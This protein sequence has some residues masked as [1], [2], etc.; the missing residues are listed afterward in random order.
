MKRQQEGITNM[1][2]M[3]FEAITIYQW[4]VDKIEED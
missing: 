3:L 2:K 4:Y 1:K